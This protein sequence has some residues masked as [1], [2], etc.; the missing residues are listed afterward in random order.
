MLVIDALIKR[1]RNGENKGEQLLSRL[2]L[3]TSFEQAQVE[4]EPTSTQ[5][6]TNDSDG[7]RRHSGRVLARAANT[8][9]GTGT[10]SP[11]PAD[12]HA[13]PIKPFLGEAAREE[14]EQRWWRQ[15][16]A[17]WPVLLAAPRLRA[18]GRVRALGVSGV[19]ETSGFNVY[20]APSAGIGYASIVIV[21][22]LNIYYIVILA[23]GVYYL[24]Q[25]GSDSPPPHRPHQRGLWL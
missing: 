4:K 15:E 3:F 8:C 24:F 21:S 10:P 18:H 5:L 6:F 1:R 11:A 23:W 19:H 25:V 12:A 13:H 9:A 14:L 7:R 20:S 17:P 2:S 22:L 16:V